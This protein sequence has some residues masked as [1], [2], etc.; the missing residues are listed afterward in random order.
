MV[1]DTVKRVAEMGVGVVLVEQNVP[2]VLAVADRVYM[3][4]K[5]AMTFTGRAEEC[6]DEVLLQHLGV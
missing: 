6:T 5:G 2:M 4:Q 1:R 3:M